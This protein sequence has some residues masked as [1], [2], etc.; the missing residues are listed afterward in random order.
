M[1]GRRA[2]AALWPATLVIRAHCNGCQPLGIRLAR[3][4]T[5]RP[6]ILVFAYC[7]HG[8]VDETVAVLDAQGKAVVV[9][10]AWRQM[11]FRNGT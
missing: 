5:R 7:Y 11:G 9:Y 4:V 8:S 2:G 3:L 6:R 10:E 1:G